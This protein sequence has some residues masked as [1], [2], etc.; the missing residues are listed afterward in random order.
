MWG[1]LAAWGRL[2]IGP[3][4]V[5]YAC[6][7]S[8]A[9]TPLMRQYNGI[10]QQVPN[11]LLMFRPL[12]SF[13]EDA[14]VAARELEITLTSRNK[15]KALGIPMCGVPFMRLRLHPRLIQKGYRAAIC[16][17][18]RSESARARQARSC[19]S[20]H[21]A[22]PQMLPVRSRENNF[23]RP[24]PALSG[25]AARSAVAPSTSTA[26]SRSPTWSPPK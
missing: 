21:P 9:S 22:Q 3:T 2:A 12:T 1:R 24:S 6:P 8:D 10:K 25:N 7:M 4:C 26:S 18:W 14:V 5:Q 17:Q 23:L 13:S 16:D 11:A 20:S 19:A 15:E